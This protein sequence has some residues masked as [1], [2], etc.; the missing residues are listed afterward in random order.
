MSEGTSALASG[1][2]GIALP[3]LMWGLD[4]LGVEI[5][6]PVVAT[7][8]AVSILFV[9][10]SLALFLHLTYK[11]FRGRRRGTAVAIV[12]A[13]AQVI[14]RMPILDFM[15]LAA[16]RGWRVFGVHNLEAV[17][18]MDGLRQVGS[19]AIVR[20]WGRLDGRRSSNAIIMEIPREH[21]QEYELDW[22]SVTDATANAT[23]CTYTMHRPDTRYEG[24]YADIHLDGAAATRWLETGALAFRGQ[25]DRRGTSRG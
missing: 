16:Q 6:K 10:L 24:G 11:W 1:V 5:S 12:E 8:V 3:T 20:F 13:R 18:L 7:I 17:D 22:T 21:W 23:T 15:R 14:Q 19:D 25:R 9:V 4:R 2:L